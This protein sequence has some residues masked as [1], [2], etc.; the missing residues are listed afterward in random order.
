MVFECS[1]GDFLATDHVVDVL[2]FASVS[3]PVAAFLY[4]T[5]PASKLPPCSGSLVHAHPLHNAISLTCS[6]A[7]L[8]ANMASLTTLLLHK[9][10]SPRYYMLRRFHCQ[11][12]FHSSIGSM[13]APS[14][15]FLC[16]H[17]YCVLL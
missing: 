4:A 15:H 5:V 8:S 7:W 6:L 17:T 12:H 10:S 2:S 9:Q 13:M 16:F 14:K 3:L 1:G 11:V